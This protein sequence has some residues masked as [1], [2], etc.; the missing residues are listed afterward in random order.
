MTSFLEVEL[1]KLE[2]ERGS[3]SPSVQHLRNQLHE[4]QTGKS[5][6]EIYCT[7]S[8]RKEPVMKKETD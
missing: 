4:E 2:A 1:I 6:Q 5:A 7:G 8:V 3:D